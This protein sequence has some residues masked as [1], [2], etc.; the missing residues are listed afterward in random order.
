MR[1]RY[2]FISMISLL[3]GLVS[4]SHP[5]AAAEKTVQQVEGGGEHTLSLQS[6]GSVWAWGQN[7]YGQLGDGSTKDRVTPAQA[8]SVTNATYLAAGY[9][10]SLALKRDG[11]VWA[12]G[13]NYNGQLGD[14]STINRAAPVQVQR[15]GS[16]AA[17]SAGT[18]YSLA[19]RRD[20]TVWAWGI[21][22]WSQ[23]GDGSRTDRHTPVQV[24]DSFHDN[25]H[26]VVAIASGDS[27]NLALKQDGT[28]WAWGFNS[29]GQI[30]VGPLWQPSK[31]VQVPR[32]QSVIAIAAKGSHSLAL[33][34]DGTVWAWGDNLPND[35]KGGFTTDSP[36]QVQGLDSVTAIASGE[37]HNLALKADGT[38]WEWGAQLGADGRIDPPV[39]VQGLRS[40]TAIA[41][42]SRHYLAVTSDGT[43]WAWGDNSYGQLGDGTTNDRHTPVQ[44]MYPNAPDTFQLSDSKTYQAGGIHYQYSLNYGYI[45]SPGQE[46]SGSWTAP[47]GFHGEVTV[48]M[49]SP[50]GV[51]VDLRLET[52]SGGNRLPEDTKALP[53]GTERSTA[54]VP[55]GDTAKWTVK[56][57]TDNDF[58]PDKKVIVYVNIKYDNQ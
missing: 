49:I 9:S 12:W 40:V 19:L 22:N 35:D 56:G 32:L 5:A 7:W 44:V 6:D 30:G 20:G 41:A 52:I 24:K 29:R 51:N 17:I 2:R 10:H 8:V 46:L 26:S 25:L 48:S 43:L 1:L 28:V 54:K 27:H 11:T 37:S 58:S 21:N 18:W 55:G 57:H 47:E 33:R 36:V 13:E 14:G 45:S 3:F 53:D 4:V 38:V 31:P 23:L 42:G 50:E 39:Q 16:V 15:L 34:N